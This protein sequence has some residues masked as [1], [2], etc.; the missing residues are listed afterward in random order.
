MCPRRNYLALTRLLAKE[1]GIDCVDSCSY[2]AHQLMY[3]PT[4]PSNGDYVFERFDGAWLNPDAFL[5]A[6]PGWRDVNLLPTS[7]RESTLIDRQR[8]QQADPLAKPGIVGAFC[9]TYSIE[10]AIDAFLSDVYQPS[11]MAGRYDYVPADSSAGVVLYDGKF[12]YSHHAT[13]PAC[14]Q[15]LSAFDLV[16]IHKFRDL[17]DKASADTAHSKLPSYKA[18]CDF[19]VQDGAVKGTLAN[20]RMEQATAE[21]ENPDEWQKLLELDKQG[22]VKDTLTNIANIVRYDPSLQNIVFNELTCMLD[23]IGLL[24]WRQVK[25]GWG[26]ADLACAKVYFEQVYGIWSPTKFKDA[27]IAVV[28]SERVYHPIKQYFDTLQWDGTERSALIRCSLIIW[29]QTTQRI[30][31][32][33]PAKPCVPLSLVCTNRV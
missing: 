32:Q 27:L 15:L 33:S 12:A 8:K 31:A 18:M 28:S 7:S 19:A 9:R 2:R 25:P 4:T 20:E 14:G 13:D 10:E 5:S 24:P 22:H 30:P 6:H 1:W 29:V 23:V 26:D 16:R 21:F 17:D 11:A 3:W